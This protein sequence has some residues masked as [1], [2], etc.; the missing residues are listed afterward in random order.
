MTVALILTAQERHD[1]ASRAQSEE[2]IRP[3]LFGEDLQ[4]KAACTAD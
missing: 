3:R 1:R 2:A 4:A